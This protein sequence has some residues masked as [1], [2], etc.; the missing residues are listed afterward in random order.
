MA[1]RWNLGWRKNWKIFRVFS[2]MRGKKFVYRPLNMKI[3]IQIWMKMQNS[4]LPK[5]EISIFEKFGFEK[6]RNRD[7]ET[8]NSVSILKSGDRNSTQNWKICTSKP[9]IW[10]RFWILGIEIWFRNFENRFFQ[11]L[12]NFNSSPRNSKSPSSKNPKS[13]FS[14]QNS[15]FS[16][17]KVLILF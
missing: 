7:I 8:W 4:T 5:F 11:F 16:S 14:L 10:L 15:N 6:I 1:R 3:L 13:T 17:T 9:E 12:S 2:E